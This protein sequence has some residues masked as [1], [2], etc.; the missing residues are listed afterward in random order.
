[1][2]ATRV[3]VA[4]RETVEAMVGAEARAAEMAARAAA[5]MARAAAAREQAA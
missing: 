1:M 5:V 3:V 2:V 4:E